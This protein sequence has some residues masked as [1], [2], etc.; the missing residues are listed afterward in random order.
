M[1]DAALF[2]LG[3]HSGLDRTSED[4]FKDR[5]DPLKGVPH[6]TMLTYLRPIVLL[7]ALK[8]H[9]EAMV[10][11]ASNSSYFPDRLFAEEKK[12]VPK[13]PYAE[14]EGSIANAVH[15]EFSPGLAEQL[16]QM[17]FFIDRGSSRTIQEYVR[18]RF[19]IPEGV[20]YRWVDQFERGRLNV[21]DLTRFCSAFSA[22]GGVEPEV[23]RREV[24]GTL[25]ACLN[26]IGQTTRQAGRTAQ[27]LRGQQSPFYLYK[28]EYI[29]V[30]RALEH[31]AINR[32]IGIW[33]EHSKAHQV[34]EA[35]LTGLSP[36]LEG[37]K[38]VVQDFKGNTRN[39]GKDDLQDTQR[40]LPY[41]LAV[42]HTFYKAA[43]E[44]RTSEGSEG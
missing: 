11:L 20:R 23:S 17:P 29:G 14:L 25:A 22:E 15:G 27:G 35:R 12:K 19:S 9:P 36:R 21:E 41:S 34:L 24:Y 32:M 42:L 31:H 18:S 4:D 8:E 2:W 33:E 40:L 26:I 10:K 30:M 38:L 7:R 16:G 1:L 3:S 6:R 44:K 43:E 39:Y 5:F 13:I 37:D 28:G